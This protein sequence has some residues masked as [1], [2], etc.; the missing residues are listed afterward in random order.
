MKLHYA[1]LYLIH[2][3]FMFNNAEEISTAWAAMEELHAQGLAKS[4]GVSNFRA[5]DLA[6]VLKTCKVVP[7]VNQIEFHPYRQRPEVMAVM[8]EHGI[9]PVGYGA[10]VSLR[11]KPGGP[12]DEYVEELAAKYSVGPPEILMR[13]Q[14]EKGMGVITTTSSE[15]HMKQYKKVGDFEMTTEEVKEIDRLGS[16]L[17]YIAYWSEFKSPGAE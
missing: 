3:P 12:V 15:E 11:K 13:W 10:L 7:A 16:K 14:V 9:L 4:I 8:N 2:A 1:D 6:T 17:Y 5:Q